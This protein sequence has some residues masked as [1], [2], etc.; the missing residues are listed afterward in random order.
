MLY[1]A[2]L[3]ACKQANAIDPD[4]EMEVGHPSWE[5]VPRH[6]RTYYRIAAR[7]FVRKLRSNDPS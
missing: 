3:A 7:N 4:C 1:E 6:V 5:T 2:E